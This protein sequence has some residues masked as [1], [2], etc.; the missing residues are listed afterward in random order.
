MLSLFGLAEKYLSVT[1]MLTNEFDSKFYLLSRYNQKS[2]PDLGRKIIWKIEQELTSKGHNEIESYQYSSRLRMLEYDN[3]M[4][5]GNISDALVSEKRSLNEF[6]K[7]FILKSVNLINQIQFGEKA[8]NIRSNMK[9]T[10]AFLSRIDLEKFLNDIYREDLIDENMN[11]ILFRL[12]YLDLMLNSPDAENSHYREMKE[13]IY[14][15][16]LKIEEKVK[17]HY[18]NRLIHYCSNQRLKGSRRFDREMFD[19]FK[20]LHE[21]DMFFVGRRNLALT[22]DF[23]TAI[24]SAAYNNEIEWAEKFISDLSKDLK[25][26]LS[27]D[28]CNYGLAILRFY[29]GRFDESLKLLST[30]EEPSMLL[31]IDTYLLKSQIFY[32]LKYFDSSLSTADTFRHH[33]D[34][35][36]D[37]SDELKEICHLFIR[38][39][40]RLITA[41]RKPDAK[42]LKA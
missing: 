22:M 27:I 3:H 6:I 33:L 29:Q 30:V 1:G 4:L 31:K 11:G 19:H 36:D 25:K 24:M 17:A 12:V 7:F 28:A 34:S 2:I 15:N 16:E 37:Y 20:F 23:R 35:S 5:I 41:R 14:S 40:R 38:I 21:N 42:S 9:L 39:L 13:M 8:Y 26:E 32:E 10:D 18:I